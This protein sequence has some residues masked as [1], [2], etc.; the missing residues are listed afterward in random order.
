MTAANKSGGREMSHRFRL[1]MFKMPV[2]ISQ[3]TEV[4]SLTFFRATLCVC[5]CV[6]VCVCSSYQFQFLWWTD[7]FR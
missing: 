3:T 7:S 2:T 1:D 6:C 5:V 4:Q